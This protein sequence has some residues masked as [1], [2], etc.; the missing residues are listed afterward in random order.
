TRTDGVADSVTATINVTVQNSSIAALSDKN[1]PKVSYNL[2]SVK[3]VPDIK[4]PKWVNRKVQEKPLFTA[5][6]FDI[7]VAQE[8]LTNQVNNALADEN[9]QTFFRK[10]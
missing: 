6:H 3:S 8:T 5:C 9:L 10:S 2:L 7:A 1:I 4:A